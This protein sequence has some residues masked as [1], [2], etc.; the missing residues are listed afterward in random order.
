MEDE[1][2]VEA[3]IVLGLRAI[4]GEMRGD[5]IEP[6]EAGGN[7]AREFIVNAAAKGVG[8][9]CIRGCR[10]LREFIIPPIGE[11]NQKMTE[12]VEPLEASVGGLGAKQ[13]QQL[14]AINVLASR[15]GG[16]AMLTT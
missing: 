9:S 5:Q 11:A 7:P 10:D 13:A 15:W 6:Q 12:N 14:F 4:H 1:T 2:S 16:G 3:P 8:P